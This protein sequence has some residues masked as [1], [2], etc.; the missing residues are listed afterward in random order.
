MA[1]LYAHVSE[2]PPAPS[3][4]ADGVTDELD[5]VVERAMA[6][7]P[8]DR[9]L[10]AGDLGRAA[11][12]AATGAPVSQ[13]EHSVATGEAAPV[14]QPAEPTP[15]KA[16]EPPPTEP[17]STVAGEPPTPA[18][19]PTEPSG[20][21]PPPARPEQP[22]PSRAGTRRRRLTALGAVLAVGAAV[23]IAVIALGGGG[24]AAPRRAR[25]RWRRR[26]R[27]RAP[28]DKN[29]G[30]GR[31]RRSTGSSRAV[32]SVELFTVDVPG[33]GSS[34]AGGPA[35]WAAHPHGLGR[36]GGRPWTF[37]FSRRSPDTAH[38]LQDAR[39]KRG[40]G[41]AVM[42]PAFRTRPS[43][44]REAYVSGTPRGAGQT[45]PARYRRGDRLQLLLRRLR[46]L[47]RTRAAVS[48]GDSDSKKART[49][50]LDSDGRDAEAE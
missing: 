33:A 48:T 42:R 27:R 3:K 34:G 37:R 38:Q 45:Q 46:F 10:S 12:S 7:E 19:P 29:G 17:A 5:V 28:P 40:A 4:L 2:P 50:P 44:G 25:R 23:A 41:A 24:G 6:K 13:P 21:P 30:G 18:P 26:R 47:W 31:A 1:K 43:R 14:T 9:Y 36:P 22:R 15:T 20:E 8:D 35:L 32:H 49:R 11:L 39:A 16:S